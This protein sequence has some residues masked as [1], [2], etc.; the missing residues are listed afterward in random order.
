[1]VKILGTES[2]VFLSVVIFSMVYFGLLN[3]L[4]VGQF[5]KRRRLS[6]ILFSLLNGGIAV[7]VEMISQ[8]RS[9]LA[10]ISLI[11]LVLTLEMYLLNRKKEKFYLYFRYFC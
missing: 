7:Y 10:V 6:Q 11:T 9:N 3:K 1:M 2:C 8:G 4:M 5:Q